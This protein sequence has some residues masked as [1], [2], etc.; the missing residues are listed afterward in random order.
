VRFAAIGGFA[1]ADVIRFPLLSSVPQ[2]IKPEPP[3]TGKR[4]NILYGDFRIL[5]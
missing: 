5:F 1:S 4:H 2:A 3:A